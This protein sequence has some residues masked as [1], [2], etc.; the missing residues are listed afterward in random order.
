MKKL[1]ALMFLLTLSVSVFPAP[2][3]MDYAVEGTNIPLYNSIIDGDQNNNTPIAP[4]EFSCDIDGI[5]PGNEYYYIVFTYAENPMPTK[6]QN[7]L[8]ENLF[9][10]KID[11]TQVTLPFVKEEREVVN[12]D[13]KIWVPQIPPIKVTEADNGTTVSY[14][15]ADALG[16][17]PGFDG[18]PTIA[19]NTYMGICTDP[20]DLSTCNMIMDHEYV[21]IS[22]FSQYE[23]KHKVENGL[24]TISYAATDNAEIDAYVFESDN[25]HLLWILTQE[26]RY[27]DN[28]QQV[29]EDRGVYIDSVDF[30]TVA[31]S[32]N[33]EVNYHTFQNPLI[34]ED[35]HYYYIVRYRRTPYVVSSY[36]YDVFY[37]ADN[38]FSYQSTGIDE[39]EIKQFVNNANKVSFECEGN[40][41]CD[42]HDVTGKIVESIPFNKTFEHNKTEKNGVY[43]YNV[44]T[45]DGKSTTIKTIGK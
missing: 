37:T 24:L 7:V 17:Q 15:W 43:L 12:Y 21:P 39:L 31:P 45:E 4:I 22:F 33:G 9:S 41:I 44:K 13:Y 14:I 8:S 30:G 25:Y 16:N 2:T 27:G 28:L 40:G 35:R 11:N 18:V 1:L 23:N 19:P 32:A 26:E 10:E 38:Y 3:C 6:G 5:E 42:I 34:S 20:Q 36:G 29:L